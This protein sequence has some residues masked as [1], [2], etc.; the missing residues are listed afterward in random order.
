MIK[1]LYCCAL[2]EDVESSQVLS[3]G[4]RY[5]PVH[6]VFCFGIL[7]QVGT[8]EGM[9]FHSWVSA[10]RNQFTNSAFVDPPFFLLPREDIQELQ[11]PNCREICSTLFISARPLAWF[12]IGRYFYTYKGIMAHSGFWLVILLVIAQGD[13]KNGMTHMGTVTLSC[14]FTTLL[15]SNTSPNCTIAIE[16]AIRILYIIGRG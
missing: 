6:S 14:T 2:E 12:S 1:L 3:Y 4:C 8:S 10:S 16:L 15:V 11:A 7:W 13:V 5:W 9:V